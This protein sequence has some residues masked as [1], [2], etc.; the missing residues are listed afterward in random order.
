VIAA[1]AAGLRLP[2]LDRRPM[3]A[4]EAILADKFGTFLETGAYPYD[5]REYHGPVLAYLAWTPAHLSGQTKYASL[6]ETT[7]RLAP[8]LAGVAL[9][10]TPFALVPAISWEAAGWAAAFLAASPAMAY[11]SRYFI[12]EI[13]LSLWTA[14]LL[15]ALARRW[16][17]LAGAALALM[18]ATK[19]TAIFALASGGVAYI[20]VF[21]SRLDYRAALRFFV[22]LF[23]GISVLLAPPWKW[24]VLAQ[25]A[26]AYWHRAT[27]GAHVHPWYSYMQWL[28]I[29]EAPILILAACAWRGSKPAV[30]FVALYALV[31]AVLYS[32]VPYKTPWC[33]VS[34]LYALAL[35]GGAGAAMLGGWRH[36]AGVLALVWMAVL[37][38]AAS[39]PFVTDPR[40]PWAYAH[41]GPG[42]FTIRDR[43]AEAARVAPEGRNVAVDVFTRENFWPL[44]WYLRSF[45][46]VRWWRQVPVQGRAAP[47]VLLSPALEPDFARKIYESPPPGQRELYVSLFAE[48]VELRPNVE[49][50]GYVA[51]SIWDPQ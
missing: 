34:L 31:L 27:G 36:L 13:P 11:Y 43:V 1:M 19:E 8:A 33:A 18:I 48:P 38:W 25:S 39:F 41:T 40:N 7:I 21:R 26:A 51:K 35:L 3:H 23:A 44:P 17:T 2:L 14:L 37:A 4:D 47:I 42:V 45:P 29:T 24:G 5:P 22:T 15:I 10:L 46:Q 49:V 50:R 12:P 32:A 9:A 28:S 6:T 20:S 16:W 30:R